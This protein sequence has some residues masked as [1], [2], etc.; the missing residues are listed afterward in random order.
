VSLSHTE[1][2]RHPSASFSAVLRVRLTDR[3]GSFARLARAIGDAGGSLGAIDIVSIEDGSKIRDVTVLAEDGD[4]IERIGAAVR[5]LDGIELEQI[6]DRTYLMHQGG[7]LEVVPKRHLETRDD[8]SMAYTPGVARISSAIVADPELAWELTVKQNTVAI[9]TDGTAVLG[10]GDIGPEAAMPVM[11]GKAVL[12]KE[13]AGI[14]A[15]PLCLATKDVDEIVRTVVAVAPGFGGINLEDISAP[16]CFEIEARLRD[17][18]PI[19]VFHDDQHGT[20]IV[21]SAALLNALRVVGKRLEEIRVVVTGVGAAGIATSKMLLGLG[22]RDVIG[23]DRHGAVCSSRED[24]GPAKQAYAEITNPNGFTGSADEALA[25]AD[26]FIGLSGPGA[27]SADGIRSMAEAAI[28]FAMANPT[29]EVAPEELEGLA[30]V[31]ATGRSDYPN[32][33]NNVLAF[34]G[35]FRGALSVR[36]DD[37]TEEMKLAASHAI[38]S[39]VGEDELSADYIIPSIFNPEVTTAV[40]EATAAAASEG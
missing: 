8:L 23:C 19:P 17:E 16:R 28:V 34:P 40:A 12:F 24:L 9:V 6:V 11:E 21:V 30:A 36:A 25:G 5:A 38:A 1:R 7:K 2:V 32:Q 39:I 35:V 22:V 18:L 27:V 13:F 3:P 29:P 33:I 15:W 10:L 4:H 14:D 37:I 20:A 26:V 31:V